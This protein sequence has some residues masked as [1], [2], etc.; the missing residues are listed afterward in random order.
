MVVVWAKDGF[1]VVVMATSGVLKETTV[2]GAFL[3]ELNEANPFKVAFTIT[4]DISGHGN[5]TTIQSAIDSIPSG[6]TM[7]IRIQIFAG[8]YREKVTITKDKTCIFLDGAGRHVTFIEWGDHELMYSS[9]TFTSVAENLVVKGIEIKQSVVHYSLGTYGHG[10]HDTG[11]ITAQGR[12]SADDPS[13]F[14]FKDCV[15][16]GEG[17][18]YLGRAF[19]GVIIANSKLS[20]IVVPQGWN[21]W[22]NVGYEDQ[23]TYLEVD[24]IGPGANTSHR[25]PWLKKLSASDLGQF[26]SVDRFVNHEGWI[27]NL[28]TIV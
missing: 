28:P 19:S 21:A 7:W 3:C 25:V 9:S 23:F 1:C 13:G 17:K 5:F 11:Y 27:A 20:D 6:N 12:D 14:V 8:V 26:L 18:A 16:L 4:V 22:F 2:V 15:I 24:N 10:S